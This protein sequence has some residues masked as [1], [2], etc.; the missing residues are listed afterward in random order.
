[1]A[2]QAVAGGYDKEQRGNLI[3]F[4]R[5]DYDAARATVAHLL[6]KAGAPSHLFDRLTSMGAPAGHG[7]STR[8]EAGSLEPRKVRSMGVTF[9]EDDSHFADEIKRVAES[10]DP[11]VMEKVN[12]YLPEFQRT[13]PFYRLMA[14]EKI[15]RAERPEL[16]KSAE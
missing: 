4:A 15:V 2:D 9:V 3:K 16:A 10:K 7:K 8:E 13:E 5:V 14:A 1:L 12:K 6:P 11:I